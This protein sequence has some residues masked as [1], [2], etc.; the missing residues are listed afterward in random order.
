MEQK[1][2]KI[3]C[4]RQSHFSQPTSP[5]DLVPRP[6][7]CPLKVENAPRERRAWHGEARWWRRRRGTLRFVL[8][9]LPSPFPLSPL[10]LATDFAAA[11]APAFAEPPPMSDAHQ[12]N[13]LLERWELLR[14]QGI[15]ISADEL[16]RD[17]PELIDDV[18]TGIDELI[19][20]DQFI[21]PSTIVSGPNPPGASPRRSICSQRPLS[22]AAESCQRRPGRN[23]S[24]PRRGD[25]P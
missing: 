3:G 10:S 4:G 25:R 2:H 15:E 19:A 7:D 22:R 8:A 11:F 12:V 5:E 18:R 6:P 23:L 20:M 24:R 14:D 16:C 1:R 21:F 13:E 17:C 9:I